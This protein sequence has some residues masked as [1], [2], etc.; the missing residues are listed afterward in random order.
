[1]NI[2]EKMLYDHFQK[3]SIVKIAVPCGNGN[4][5]IIATGKLLVE[6]IPRVGTEY[7][8]VLDGKHSSID[9]QYAFVGFSSR[10]V[11][12]IVEDQIYLE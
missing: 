4:C 11:N 12:Q 3:R 1:M 10:N 9:S 5:Q 6:Y 7:R 8:V 2:V